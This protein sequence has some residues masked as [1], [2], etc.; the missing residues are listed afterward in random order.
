M[1]QDRADRLSD[2]VEERTLAQCQVLYSEALTKAVRRA[3]SVFDQLKA[4]DEKKPPSVYDTPEKQEEWRSNE[5]RR[6]LRQSGLANLIAR[7]TAAAGAQAA[8]LIRSSMDEIERINRVV[9]DIGEA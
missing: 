7:E 8:V 1:E 5:K 2:R 6:I 4:V 9:D 3:A